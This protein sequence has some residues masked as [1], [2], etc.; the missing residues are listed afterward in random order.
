MGQLVNQ[1]IPCLFLVAIQFGLALPWLWAID[2]KSF[3]EFSR[4]ASTWGVIVGLVAGIALFGAFVLTFQRITTSLEMAGRFYGA[5]LS[6][7]LAVDLFLVA[8]YGMLK[9]WP[10]GGAVA[11][12]AFREGIR[13]PMFWLIGLVSIALLFVAMLFPFFTFGDDYK[14]MKQIC[15]DTALLAGVLFGVLGA[16]I[17]INEEIEGRTAVTLMS[18]PVTRR[19]FL[20]GKFVGILLAS[21][22]LTLIIGWFFIWFLYWQPQLNPYDEV[23]DPMSKQTLAL[24]QP[25]FSKIS[26]F[27]ATQAMT[28]LKQFENGFVSWS[29]EAL[30]NGLGLALGFGKV[31]VLLAIAATL[32]TR[33]G[34]VSNLVLCLAIFFLGHLAPVLHRVSEEL[35][36]QSPNNTAFS[37]VNFLTQIMETFTPALEYFNMG[38]AIIR[39]TPLSVP[40]FAQYVGSVVAYSAIYAVIALLFGLILFED[41]DLA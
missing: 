36:S 12:A 8:I 31:A 11:L 25:Y 2:P 29:S 41:R 22:A 17:S 9:L 37:L 4:R 33:M 7:Q 1:F 35:K 18:K 28:G 13:Q 6:I 16:S 26:S 27:D 5:F 24:L 10:K 15:F 34:M 40:A 30:S 19:Q 20:L 38:P 23:V 14:M 21:W 3:R 39:D 32:A